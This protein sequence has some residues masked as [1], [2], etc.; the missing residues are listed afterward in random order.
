MYRIHPE[1]DQEPRL[2]LVP[3]ML[4][5]H[6]PLLRYALWSKEYRPVILDNETG[7]TELGLKYVNNDMCYP[8]I[9]NVGQL[10]GAL[11]SGQYP[12]DRVHLLMPTLG[13]S[14][15]GS[16]YISALRK[17]VAAAGF[18]V[19]VMSMN[20]QGLERGH[21]IP[22][23]PYMVWRGLFAMVYGDMLMHLLHQVRPCEQ[24]PGAASA[25]RTQWF[26][27]LGEDLCTGRHLT[28]GT[29]KRN[30][31]AMAADF[32]AIPTTGETRQRIGLI[33]DIYTKYCHLGNWDVVAFLEAQ[34]CEVCR[35]GLTSYVLYYLDSHRPEG[36]L[37]QLFSPVAALVLHLQKAML[38]ALGDYGFSCPPDF[39]TM[40]QE[41]MADVPMGITVGD[42][43]LLGAEALGM[44]HHQCHKVLAVHPFGCLPGHVCG[45][46]YY[47]S[48][49]RKVQEGQILSVDVDASGS[50][51]SFYNRVKMLVD[52]PVRWQHP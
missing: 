42:G 46:G 27:R 5:D 33:G 20:L 36:P 22:I 28:L 48:L 38:Q 52:M 45:K 16:N 44:L 18:S 11:E 9:L 10:L 6:F 12:L 29:L 31:R 21:C 8:C 26:Q 34:G 40:K 39:R 30:L 13:D 37:G 43:W 35:G 25:C 17:A 15:R 2:L 50:Q 14:C 32:A 41:A 4:D 3:A 51:V 47:P 7:I 24:V 49:N 1:R 23:H 19:P